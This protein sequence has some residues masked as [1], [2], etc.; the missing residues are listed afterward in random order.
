MTVGAVDPLWTA[1]GAAPIRFG[2]RD[3]E[4]PVIDRSAL[5][6]RIGA[7]LDR[8]LRPKVLLATQTRLLEPCLDREGTAAPATPLIAVHADPEHLA[9][10]AAVLL[11]PPVVAW[12]WRRWF[13]TA[14]AID[15]VK[16]AARQVGEL[17][18]P[19]DLDRWGEAAALLDAT[20]PG[21]AGGGPDPGRAGARSVAVAVARLM[22]EAYG[23][24]PAVLDWW[25]DRLPGVSPEIVEARPEQ[26]R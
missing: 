21:R 9:R 26:V 8:Q 25:R 2:G 12:A 7:W 15:A 18:L 11:A 3:W 19:V 6:P 22:T 14:M 20:G 24:E 1:W 23:A 5:P 13:G 10:V 16:L 4:R 17:P